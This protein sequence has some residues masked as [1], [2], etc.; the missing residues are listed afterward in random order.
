MLIDKMMPEYLS[1]A[2]TLV[3]PVDD[4]IKSDLARDL[5]LSEREISQ[6]IRYK[7]KVTKRR[8]NFQKIIRNL[9]STKD[10]IFKELDKCKSLFDRVRAVISPEKQIKY[11]FWSHQNISRTDFS[12]QHTWHIH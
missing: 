8:A 12:T 9:I 3:G 2:F 6:L 1:V 11:M 5:E 10:Q 7:E 4:Q